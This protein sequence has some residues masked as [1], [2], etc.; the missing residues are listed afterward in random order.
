MGKRLFGTRKCYFEFREF[1]CIVYMCWVE[2]EISGHLNG[3]V[4]W[5][6]TVFEIWECL[7]EIGEWLFKIAEPLFEILEQKRIPWFKIN[8]FPISNNVNISNKS[9]KW[10]HRDNLTWLRNVTKDMG[11]KIV[12]GI[13]FWIKAYATVLDLFL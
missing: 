8:F 9:F 13:F 12:E 1:L 5:E 10:P 7:F 2:C 11:S 4:I 6:R 3:Y